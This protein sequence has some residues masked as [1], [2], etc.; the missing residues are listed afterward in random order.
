MKSFLL[1]VF[2]FLSLAASGNDDPQS[3][4][5][6]SFKLPKGITA[7][8]YLPN[9]LII[10]FRKG[11]SD[12]DIRSATSLFGLNSLKLKSVDIKQVNQIFK[13]VLLSKSGQ[14]SLDIQS[15]DSIGLDRVFEF[16]F[17]SEKGIVEIINEVLGNRMVEYAEPSY[18]YHTSFIPND[19]F[20]TGGFQN[21]L[22]QI[23]AEQ[24]WD[25]IRNSSN[26]V[27]AI[28]DS[29][30]DMDHADLKANILLPGKDLVG[31]SFNTL[32]ED[33]DPDVK[34]DSTDHGVRVSGMASAVSDNGIGISSVAS[35]AKLLIIKAGADNN[36]STIYRGYE[37]I[38]YAADNGAHIINCSW[39]GPGGGAFGQDV[40]NYAI[41]KGCLV[42]V[43]AGNSNTITPEYPANYT[44]V[45]AVA[46]V[47][48]NDRKNSFSNF[49]SHVSI[50]APGE[51]FTT[52]NGNKYSVAR[53]TSLATPIVSSAAALV[54]SRF[55][56]YDMQQVKEQLMVT[57]DNLDASN[58]SFSGYLGKGRLNVFRALTEAVPAIRYQNIT[59]LDK[60]RGSRPSGDTLR[61]FFD[62]KNILSPATG[63]LAKLSSDNP[64]IQII[65]QDLV[66]GNMATRELKTMFGPFRVY[67]KPGI[68][69]NSLVN[70]TISY[71]AGT[72]YAE[73]EKFQIRVALD[74]LN[75]EVNQ[76]STTI[77][78]NGRIGYTDQGSKSGLGFIYKN[79]PLLFE[80][81]LM[82][83]ASAVKVSNNTR[84][85]SGGSDEHFIKKKVVYKE[86]DPTAAFL[87]RS[88]FDDSGNS[89]RL[90]LYVKHNIKAFAAAPDDKYVLAEYEIGNNG[91]TVLNGIY[92][93]LFTDW[94]VD[95][96]GTDITKYDITN[97]MA[98]V[99]G[100]YGATPYAG[101]K[102][103]SSDVQPLYY[104]L[105][106]QVLGDP[107]QTGNGLSLAEKYQILS[108]GIK[109]LSLGE[110]S[111]NG[112]D[113]MFVSGY[114]P[115]TIPVNGS[116]KVAF[117]LLAGDNLADLQASAVS[118]Q[119]KYDELNI[120]T[121]GLPDN[122]FVLQQNYPNPAADQSRIE[123]VIDKA[124]LV[125]LSLYNSAGQPVK[126]LFDG[127]LDKGSYSINV[128]LASLNPGIYFYKMLF[129][130]KEKTLKMIISK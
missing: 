75:I 100:K 28:V 77:S 63:V 61:I 107:L 115:Y 101:V 108:S 96:Y 91:S 14:F 59:I 106:A 32:L 16:N 6:R 42:I 111:A 123:F 71:S 23:K 31:A 121:T 114:G 128:E 39:G 50:S 93:G 11:V 5:P 26:T 64:N 95:I 112:Y 13:S 45:M 113:V 74:Y 17:D 85:D 15:A 67:L 49:G 129:E 47:D 40:I 21:F 104:P 119:K 20:Y 19:P 22:K 97:R 9:T 82:I 57:S 109:V 84:N 12:T 62:L 69:D 116:I 125:S 80:A 10:K 51:V 83:G 126:D 90:N 68:P 124:G 7:K 4:N 58:P 78:S 117:A 66:V 30:S 92:A 70:F 35:N 88:E 120:K 118:A 65:D 89:S 127:S 38:K 73:N 81:S 37:G 98:Y 87:S 54:R 34:S 3:V 122:G 110:N 43:A 44:G 102:L 103:L 18:I 53:G 130:G 76:V 24:S 79:D 55:P 8:D 60:G 27:I 99:Y 72:T 46:S 36:G 52:A 48:I 94:D 41:A 33:N 86:A 29:G 105:S 1:L 2:F 25:L 56:L